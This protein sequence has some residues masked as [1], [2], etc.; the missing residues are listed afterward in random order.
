MSTNDI[1]SHKGSP[2][3]SSTASPT[4]SSNST[5]PSRSKH[6][7]AIAGGT[8]GGVAALCILAGLTLWLLRRKKNGH[9]RQESYSHVNHHDM[10]QAPITRQTPE[11]ANPQVYHRDMNE[12]SGPRQTPELADEQARLDQIELDTS[13]RDMQNNLRGTRT[14]RTAKESGG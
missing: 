8:V 10:N 9:M 3:T 7:G 2:T 11:L 4:G 12:A 1:L 14:A 13:D 5:S 6:T